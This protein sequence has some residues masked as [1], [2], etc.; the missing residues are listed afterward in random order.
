MDKVGKRDRNCILK[1]YEEFLNIPEED[2]IES[3]FKIFR[4]R[5]R[6]GSV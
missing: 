1:N 3:L 5:A 6:Y 4:R 2:R